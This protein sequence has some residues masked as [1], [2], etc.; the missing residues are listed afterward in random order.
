MS[1]SLTTGEVEMTPTQAVS[2]AAA[3]HG[4]LWGERA[5][6]WAGTEE[7]QAPTYEEAIRHVG[8]VAAQRVLEVGCGTGVFLRLVA[9]RGALAYGVDASPALVG[10]ASESVPEADVRVGD[11]QALPFED[12]SFDV[13]AGFNAFFFADDMVA[14]LREAGRVAKPGAPVVI[15]VWGRPERC[16][17]TPMKAAMTPFLPAP[18]PGA[19]AAPPQWQP[20]VLEGI[21]EQAGLAPHETF[22]LSWAYEWPDDEA[23]ARALLSPG[24]AVQAIRDAGEEPVRAAVLEAIADCR[25]PDRSYSVENEW[26]YLIARA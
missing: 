23:I 24:L 19:P 18:P 3:R 6:D 2:E 9:D 25:R 16:E 26:H 17:L 20:G 15:Q 12:D 8:I 11:M 13:V 14:A 5:R 10:L 4:D 22:D 1:H 21:A 7:Q